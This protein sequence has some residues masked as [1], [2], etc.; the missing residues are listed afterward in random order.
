MEFPQ[1]HSHNSL[2]CVY[3][4]FPVPEADV[5]DEAVKRILVVTDPPSSSTVSVVEH[6]YT[7]PLTVPSN[8][9]L[10]GGEHT[11]PEIKANVNVSPVWSIV[12]VPDASRPGLQ[13]IPPTAQ[14]SDNA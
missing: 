7:E 13:L 6:V 5:V 1:L 10:S 9:Q 3:L 4:E 2:G 11:T 8:V 12:Q 14:L